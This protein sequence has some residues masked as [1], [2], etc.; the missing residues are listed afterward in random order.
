M[1]ASRRPPE[2]TAMGT[3]RALVAAALL[4]GCGIFRS[5]SFELTREMPPDFEL[6]LDVRDATDPPIDYRLH[7]DRAG[8]ASYDVVV[9][10]PQ[11]REDSGEFDVTERQVLSLWEA[12]QKARFDR[13]DARY[14]SR[15]DGPDPRGGV[16]KVFVAAN[17]GE[18]RVESWFQVVPEIE[19]VRA[20]AVAAAPAS[21]MSASGAPLSAK[22][23][24]RAFVGDS[25]SRLFHRPGC[26]AAADVPEE[27]RTEFKTHY[28]ALNFGYEPCPDCKP[29]RGR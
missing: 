3:A 18:R 12:V 23:A 16:Q 2:P 15:G 1:D 27:S 29:I 10:S 22:D 9:R 6:S 11:R 28:D 26:K 17:G 24:P 19:T 20:A 5:Q 7:Y 13:L 4:T 21:V 25:R 14:P 8:H